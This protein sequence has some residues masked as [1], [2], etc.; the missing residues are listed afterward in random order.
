LVL[1][2]SLFL[3]DALGVEDIVIQSI[4][5]M[6]GGRAVGRVVEDGV[7]GPPQGGAGSGQIS[8]IDLLEV[9]DDGI[10]IRI[11]LPFVLAEELGDPLGFSPWHWGHRW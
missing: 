5:I 1:R 4:C 6:L 3:R 2:I 7:R 10:L 8:S 9:P 11:A